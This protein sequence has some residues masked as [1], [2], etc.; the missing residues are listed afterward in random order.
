MDVIFM[1]SIWFGFKR[2]PKYEHGDGFCSL[3]NN[4]LSEDKVRRI[5]CDVVDIERE[6]VCDSLPCDHV[7]N[8]DEF[9]AYESVH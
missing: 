8:K 2:E 5:V 7:G 3:L 9:Q 4:K 1:L 6:F